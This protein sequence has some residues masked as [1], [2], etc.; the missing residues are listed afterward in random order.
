MAESKPY[1][2]ACDCDCF[3]EGGVLKPPGGGGVP[4]GLKGPSESDPPAPSPTDPGTPGGPTTPGEKKGEKKTKP[5]KAPPSSPGRSDSRAPSDS[6]STSPAE[7]LALHVW[8]LDTAKSSFEPD[9][10]GTAR[11]SNWTQSMLGPQ[12]GEATDWV[13]GHAEPR[14]LDRPL[15]DEDAPHQTELLRQQLDGFEY[16]DRA[17]WESHA[18]ELELRQNLIDPYVADQPQTTA[19]AV[20]PCKADGSIGAPEY[21][22][23]F[24]GQ[25]VPW[26]IRDLIVQHEGWH[27]GDKELAKACAKWRAA[28]KA[29]K[30][31][32]TGDTRRAEKTAKAE[33]MV[34]L[35]K[36]ELEAHADD[37]ACIKKLAACCKK[38]GSKRGRGN[39][40]KPKK[41]KKQ[42]KG[43]V[44]CCDCRSL[45]LF[46]IFVGGSVERNKKD[47]KAAEKE[48]KSL[49]R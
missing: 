1:K 41:G 45:R 25:S 27:Q 9:P 20:S 33:W 42:G 7:W 11:S 17:D 36:G 23:R 29:R 39:T 21:S 24:Y 43:K 46:G 14:F 37:L 49:A 22:W 40:S 19:Y 3:G 28:Q 5:L 34:A 44:F 13:P 12:L 2:S 18:D 32:N 16:L 35:K 30:N 48:L 4:P 26:C 8:H 10:W 47:K 15:P 31:D 6:E 38:K